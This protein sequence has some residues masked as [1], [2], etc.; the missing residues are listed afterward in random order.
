MVVNGWRMLIDLLVS[1]GDF[2]YLIGWSEQDLY[3]FGIDI[4]FVF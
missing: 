3:L 4:V 2:G 1:L